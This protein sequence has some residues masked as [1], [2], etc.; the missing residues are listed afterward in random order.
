MAQ[1]GKVALQYNG[2]AIIFREMR[3]GAKAVW[4]VSENSSDLVQPPFPKWRASIGL[5]RC[6]VCKYYEYSPNTVSTAGN[7][8]LRW[9]TAVCH[10]LG[11]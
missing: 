11:P 4:N 8:H 7:Q 3:G 2:G 6:L 5:G 9:L 10:V 1:F